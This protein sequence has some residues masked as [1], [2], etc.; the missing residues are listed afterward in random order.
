MSIHVTENID[1]ATRF[2]SKDEAIEA[3]KVMSEC[4]HCRSWTKSSSEG[5]ACNVIKIHD[6]F[7]IV[8]SYSSG[9]WIYAQEQVHYQPAAVNEK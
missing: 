3:A 9:R 5:S 8:K 7:F 6:T 1:Y 2:T 4:A